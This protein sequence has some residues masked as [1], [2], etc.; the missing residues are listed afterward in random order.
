MLELGGAGGGGQEKY[1]M[2]IISSVFVAPMGLSNMLKS[3]C[4]SLL[5]F[6]VG[7][8]IFTLPSCSMSPALLDHPLPFSF[9]VSPPQ[10]NARVP[11]HSMGLPTP[12]VVLAVVLS[13]AILVVGCAL[14]GTSRAKMGAD[15]ESL[16]ILCTVV[17]CG[18]CVWQ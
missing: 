9:Q 13:V 17:V 12:I 18:I 8:P 2:S 7:V 4:S 6:S 10:D 16:D 3:A 1:C 14:R 15:I 5:S 11:L